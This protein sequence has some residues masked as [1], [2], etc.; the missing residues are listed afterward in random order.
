MKKGITHLGSLSQSNRAN[1]WA[2]AYQNPYTSASALCAWHTVA[3]CDVRFWACARCIV[4]FLWLISMLLCWTLFIS[5]SSSIAAAA[6]P[7]AASRQQRDA[8]EYANIEKVRCVHVWS[9]ATA[10]CMSADKRTT[11]GSSC[12]TANGFGCAQTAHKLR[13]TVAIRHTDTMQL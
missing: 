7:T 12:A 2:R 9:A 6:T 1:V 13:T 4:R 5:S 3:I 11:S 8:C 10:S